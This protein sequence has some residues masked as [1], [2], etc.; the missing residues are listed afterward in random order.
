MAIVN[1]IMAERMQEIIDETI[2]AASVIGTTLRLSKEGGGVV[3]VNLVELLIKV[4]VEVSEDYT[5]LESDAG[6]LLVVN[7]PGPVEITIPE[8]ECPIGSIL[9]GIQYG[10]ETATLVGTGDVSVE[11]HVGLVSAG[12]FARFEVLK[13]YDNL[14]VASGDLTF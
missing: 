1:G 13:M 11:S 5:V 12:Q 7:S 3:E 10:S 4:K 9:Y 14:W 2:T 6:K 8:L